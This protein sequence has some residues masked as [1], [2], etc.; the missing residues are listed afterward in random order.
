MRYIVHP[1]AIHGGDLTVPGDK[2]ISHRALMFAAIADGQSSV[3]GFLTGEDCLAT[4]A[5]LRAMGVVIEDR[6]D[7]RLVVHG[8]GRQGLREPSGTLDM[9]NSGTAM[10]LFTGLLAGQAFDCQLTGDDS[11]TGRPMGRVIAPL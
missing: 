6:G 11:L 2:S 7:S 5:A 10:R 3:S 8:R 4:M 9:G 1:A